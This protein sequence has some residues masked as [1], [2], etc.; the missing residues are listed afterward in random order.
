MRRSNPYHRKVPENTA[1]G[2]SGIQR[3]LQLVKQ[4]HL[5][6]LRHPH[7]GEAAEGGVR[8]CMERNAMQCAA[9][10]HTQRQATKKDER[11]KRKRVAHAA[12]WPN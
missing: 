5:L 7:A 6:L 2:R 3:A 10:W 8:V 9:N 11:D 1:R 12:I 4:R